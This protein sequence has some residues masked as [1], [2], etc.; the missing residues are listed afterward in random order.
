MGYSKKLRYLNDL[1]TAFSLMTSPG[2]G[3]KVYLDPHLLPL[4]CE[5][6]VATIDD[7]VSSGS[8]L[9]AVW[10]LLGGLCEICICGVVMKQGGRWESVL[11]E[12]RSSKM[13]GVFESP[14]LKT[15]EGGW[16]LRD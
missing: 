2:V 14:L 3:E 11:G 16:D 12:E 13:V 4:I 7:P 9:S 1:S 10:D 6:R 8:T 15:V 5:K